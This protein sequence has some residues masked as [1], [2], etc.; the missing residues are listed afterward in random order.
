M[1]QNAILGVGGAIAR[2]LP[3]Y[4]PRPQQTDMA[5]AVA[6][7]IA[8][9]EHLMVEA[10]TGVGKSF[11]YLVPAIEAACAD[12][13]CRI[14]IS[15]HTISLQE[16]LIRKDIPFLQEVM[17][18]PFLPL[19][20]KG[21]GNYLSRRRLRVAEKRGG[22]LLSEPSGLEQLDALGR[23]ARS[24]TDGTRSDLE[25]RPFGAV[26]ELVES[27][28]GNCLGK[29]CPDYSGCFYF[30]ARKLLHQANVL[31][32]NHALFFTDLMLRSLGRDVGILP[33]YRVVIFDE[34][35]NLEDVAADHLG[36]SIT[37]GQAEYLLNRLFQERRGTA[38]GLLSVHGGPG[39]LEQ[40]AAARRATDEFFNT[41]QNW[42]WQQERKNS[43]APQASDTL[44]VRTPEIVP[45]R[46][47]DPFLKLATLLEGIAGKIDKAEERIEY[48]SAALRCQDLATRVQAWLG[49]KLPDQVYWVEGNGDR[50]QKLCL[51]SAP[52]EVGALLRKQIFERT[53]SVILTSA[54]LSAGGR[55]GFEHLKERLGYPDHPTLQLGSPFDYARQVELHL[56]R[57]MPDPST[58]GKL[59]EEASLSKIR[60]FVARTRGRAFVLFTSNQAL[61]R[62]ATQLRSWCRDQGLTLLCQGEGL[63]AARLVE[64]FRSAEGAVLLG[65]DSFWQGVDV[66]GE[67]LSNVIITKLPFTPP[68]RPVVEARGEAIRAR[69]GEPFWDYHLPQAIIKLKQGFGRLIRTRTD[70]GLVVVLDPRV[71]TKP[72]GRRF[73]EALPPCRRFVD[74]AEVGSPECF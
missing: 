16:Q 30:K 51:A 67:A 31:I 69:G 64:Q 68:D 52:I 28:S 33:K 71:M 29:S 24:T 58:A 38:H 18:E 45:D 13:E 48:D 34:A 53:P 19:L 10:G 6:S 25:F 46:F 72:Y 22:A 41:V 42:R 12:K 17:P 35:H 44:R 59:F 49:Q 50:A 20:V 74:G 14:V 70:R 8:R 47:S 39:A 9:G 37:R 43:R 61:Q 5:N 11:A 27:D 3:N 32:V 66:Q 60:E 2:R 57:K 63:S 73:V 36:L 1:S 4:E 40:V 62:A 55:G 21:R 15:T 56:F 26:W 7:A 54:T 65:V 23:W